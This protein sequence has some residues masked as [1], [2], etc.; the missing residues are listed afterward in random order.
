MPDKNPMELT[1]LQMSTDNRHPRRQLLAS[2]LEKIN[3]AQDYSL[4]SFVQFPVVD[5]VRQEYLASVDKESAAINNNPNYNWLDRWALKR[6]AKIKTPTEQEYVNPYKIKQQPTPQIKTQQFTL[7]NSPYNRQFFDNWDLFTA[8]PEAAK[9]TPEVVVKPSVKPKTTDWNQV[10][11]DSGF[12]DIN[13]V[14][15]YQKILGVAADGKWGKK[16]N[17]ARDYYLD[18]VN[19]GWEQGT[20]NDGSTYFIDPTTNERVWASGKREAGQPV[21]KTQVI[22]ESEK[23]QTVNPPVNNTIITNPIQRIG[24]MPISEEVQQRYAEQQ[25]KKQ[26]QQIAHQNMQQK[27]NKMF[28]QGEYKTFNGTQYRRYDPA[29]P[30]DYWIDYNTGKVFNS[31]FGGDLGTEVNLKQGH[32]APRIQQYYNDMQKSLQTYKKH[33]QGGQ[34]NR[35]KYFQQGGAAQ[36]SIEEEVISLVQA[37]MQGDQ[38]ATQQVEQ[39]LSKAQQGDPQAAQLAQLIQQALES[40]KGQA[41]RAKWGSKLGYI[42]HLKSGKKNCPECGQPVEKKACGGK[43]AKKKYFGGWL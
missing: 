42:Q 34:V 19:K 29:G 7:D 14:K 10:A 20:A 28:G 37:A 21:K 17:A 40:L 36:P 27:L 41:T 1:R 8:K 13:E 9:T 31:A 5:P 11:K 6:A 15:E 33:K 38:Q 23:S 3:S 16:S 18:L 26:Q 24:N 4:P 12:N 30:G 43:K 22:K 32:S 35:V 39:I 2:D 25:R